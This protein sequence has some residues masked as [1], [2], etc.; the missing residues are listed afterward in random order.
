[1]N[2][3]TEGK[4]K[5]HFH[6][7][8]APRARSLVCVVLALAAATLAGCGDRDKDAAKP[9]QA[10]A[11]V[12]GKEITAL[13]LNEELQRANVPASQQDAASKQ[14][15]RALIDR[16]I[17]E[18]AADAEEVDR[19]P[20]VVQAI[21]RAKSMIIAQAYL[22]KKVGSV[23]PPTPGEVADFYNRNPD[24]F[25]NRKQ[26]DMRQLVLD[27]K[28]LNDEV[29]RAADNAKSIDEVAAWLDQH[30]V[31]YSPAQAS[32]TSTDL[33]L[34]L[35]AKLKDM[36]RGKLFAVKEGERTMLVSLSDVKDAPI[37]LDLARPQIER[38][39]VARKGKE[40]ADAELARLRSTAKVEYLNK[41]YAVAAAPAGGAAA[42]AAGAPLASGG[43]QP[44]AAAMQT[45]A[46]PAAGATQ[47][48]ATQAGATQAGAADAAP[49]PSEDATARG[50]AGLK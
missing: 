11:S 49:R 12:N 46:T 13:Q 18:N 50:V 30:H 24:L 36:P 2:N 47:A 35:N 32:R 33:P 34:E 25:A 4:L 7:E 9:S 29:K 37:T 48:G 27:T 23:A 14:L 17:L 40:A 21:E 19:D 3:L 45:G 38:L 20:K 41:D 42:G 8:R 6:V 1:L 22:Q 16:Q 26:Y 28:D 44:G 15:L 10:L 31:K 5:T 39:L 43:D